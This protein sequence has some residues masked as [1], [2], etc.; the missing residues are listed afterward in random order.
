MGVGGGRQGRNLIPATGREELVGPGRHG[1]G[2]AERG[3]RGR[4]G[5]AGRIQ[6]DREIKNLNFVERRVSGTV[7]RW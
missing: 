4:R 1:K 2:Q 3:R 5:E 7:V 6:Y